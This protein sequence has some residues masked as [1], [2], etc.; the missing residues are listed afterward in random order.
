MGDDEYEGKPTEYGWAVPY[1]IATIVYF[2]G[3]NDTFIVRLD[4]ML[5]LHGQAFTEIGNELSFLTPYLYNFVNANYKT[6]ETT[7]YLINTKYYTGPSGLCGN[8]DAGAIQ[9]WLFFA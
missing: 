4:D 8:S 9:A 1:D 2:I 7:R 3:N 5:G 6:A